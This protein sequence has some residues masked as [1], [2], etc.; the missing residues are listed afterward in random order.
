MRAL[1]VQFEPSD[2]SVEY[3]ADSKRNWFGQGFGGANNVA[4]WRRPEPVD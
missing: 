4:V 2:G 1:N 3:V